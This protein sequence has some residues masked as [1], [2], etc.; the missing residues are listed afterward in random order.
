MAEFC[1][2]IA[3]FTAQVCSSFDSTRDYCRKYLTDK[4][5]DFSV[6]VTEDML[7]FEQQALDEEAEQ[8]G[9]RK[10]V[11]T[12]PFLER[13]AIQR[14]V[15]EQ[16]LDR[17]V[18][19]FHG[20]A[21]AADGKGYLFTAPCGTG[22]STHARLWLQELGDRAQIINDDKPFLRLTDDR[23]FV[24]GA[25]WSGKH[26]LD[27]NICVPLQAIC[28]LERGKENRIVPAVSSEVRAF[29]AHQCLAPRQAERQ[30]AFEQL[31]HSLADTVPLFC[32]QCTPQPEAARMAYRAMAPLQF[33][34]NMV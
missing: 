30:K 15:A 11:F 34:Q 3:G 24:C 33:P 6:S 29:L 27:N 23:F 26:G 2:E 12:R 5:A 1:M 21:L 13:A 22:K 9:L 7:D 28:I 4:P 32:M 17:D 31:V 19:L 18:L 8:E 25:P 10:R 16:L 14:Q 20:S